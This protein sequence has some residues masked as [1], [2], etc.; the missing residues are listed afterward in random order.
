MLSERIVFSAPVCYLVYFNMFSFYIYAMRGFINMLQWMLLLPEVCPASWDCKGKFVMAIK[1][2]QPNDTNSSMTEVEKKCDAGRDMILSWIKSAGVWVTE[3]CDENL[4]T[5]KET[6]VCVHITIPLPIPWLSA[7]R[8][9]APSA[10]K[11]PGC[12]TFCSSD[13]HSPRNTS[14]CPT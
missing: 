7:G 8:T 1:P 11:L 6:C 12:C 13:G 5:Q 10:L 9:T 14:S 3:E 4:F 2:T